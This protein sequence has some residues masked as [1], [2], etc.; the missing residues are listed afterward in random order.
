MQGYKNVIVIRIMVALLI[1][2]AIFVL[3]RKTL[4]APVLRHGGGTHQAAIA[5]DPPQ[6]FLGSSNEPLTRQRK[7]E[8]K[9]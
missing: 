5:L 8:T 2:Y 6:I 9:P 3:I 7:E 4:S 1:L